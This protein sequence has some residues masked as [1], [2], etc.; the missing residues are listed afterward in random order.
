MLRLVAELMVSGERKRA[1][2]YLSNCP[3]KY[4]EVV[5]QAVAF[6]SWCYEIKR[7]RDKFSHVC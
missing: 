5:K 6:V 2:P 4:K 7:E 3:Y 1:L